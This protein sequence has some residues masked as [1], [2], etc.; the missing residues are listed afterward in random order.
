QLNDINISTDIG[1]IKLDGVQAA[2]TTI[3]NN[4]SDVHIKDSKLESV[5]MKS[6][7]S[8][9]AFENSTLKNGNFK[10]HSGG[11]SGDHSLVKESIFILGKGHI[12]FSKMANSCD[13]KSSTKSGN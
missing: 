3:W 7:S 5:D 2:T 12:N 8:K 4:I 9:L 1:A 13:I 10:I 11:I 6:E